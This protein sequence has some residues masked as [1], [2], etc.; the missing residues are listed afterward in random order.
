M[1]STCI[2]IRMIADCSNFEIG[3]NISVSGKF[4]AL[5]RLYKVIHPSLRCLG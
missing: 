3:C 4:K 2:C 5:G 1:S